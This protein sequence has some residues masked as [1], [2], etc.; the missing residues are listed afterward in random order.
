MDVT[1]D[2]REAH[3]SDRELL[4]TLLARYLRELSQYGAFSAAA[5]HIQRY[6]YLDAYFAE[7]GRYPFLIWHDEKI[8]GFVLVRDPFST[9]GAWQIA[10]FY[11]TPESRRLGIGRAAVTSM[12]RRFPGAWELQVHARN[13]TARQFWTSCV[14]NVADGS[15]EVRKIETDDGPRFQF[16]FRVLG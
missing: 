12:W 16:N 13:G 9:G 7:P 2:L 11:I 8:A 4:A 1:V 3:S 5:A 15:P 14:E 6:P 10:E